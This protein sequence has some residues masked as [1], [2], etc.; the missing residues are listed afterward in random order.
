LEYKCCQGGI[1]VLQNKLSVNI[2]LGDVVSFST[3]S[4]KITEQGYE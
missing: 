3:E 2:G 1:Y 4:I